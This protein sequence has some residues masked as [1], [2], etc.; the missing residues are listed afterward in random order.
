MPAERPEEDDVRRHRGHL[1]RL[2]E[3]SSA[4]RIRS[5]RSSMRSV[6]PAVPA[7]SCVGASA[8]TSS[9]ETWTVATSPSEREVA[10][11][12]PGSTR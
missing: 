3:T 10:E 8:A 1:G 11:R 9:A 6:G 7:G 12:Q 2:G 5:T 4:T